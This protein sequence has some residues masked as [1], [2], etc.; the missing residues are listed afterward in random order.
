MLGKSIAI[1][2]FIPIESPVHRLDPRVKILVSAILIVALFIVKEWLSFLFIGCFIILLTITAR[3]PIS[4]IGKS[5]KPILFLLAF[6]LVLQVFFT[7][8]DYIWEYGFLHVSREGLIRGL[9][10]STKL[11]LL[12]HFDVLSFNFCMNILSILYQIN[13]DNKITTVIKIIV[14]LKKRISAILNLRTRSRLRPIPP[15]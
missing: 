10:I 5:L 14:M 7:P 13:Q 12:V 4:Y 15:R 8:G 2:Q 3:I 11:L 9:F 1:G 6:T